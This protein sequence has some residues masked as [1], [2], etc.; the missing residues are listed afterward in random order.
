MKDIKAERLIKVLFDK[1]LYTGWSCIKTNVKV[2]GFRGYIAT[3]TRVDGTKLT[4]KGRTQYQSILNAITQNI[5]DSDLRDRFLC[6]IFNQ[7][8][9]DNNLLVITGREN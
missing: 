4:G 7:P 5:F 6:D 8:A 9:F 2:H 3:L 1:G